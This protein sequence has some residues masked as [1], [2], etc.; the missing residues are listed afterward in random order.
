[1][2][3]RRRVRLSGV[4]IL[5][6]SALVLSG[7]AAGPEPDAAQA[8]LTAFQ[9]RVLDDYIVFE[10]AQE[11][12]EENG[13]TWREYYAHLFDVRHNPRALAVDWL[14]EHEARHRGT[15][16]GLDALHAALGYLCY[17]DYSQGL[18]REKSPAYYELL[19]DHYTRFESLGEVCYYG[20]LFEDP[21]DFLL[22]MELFTAKSSHRSVQARAIAAKMLLHRRAGEHEEQRGCAEILMESYPDIL[23]QN[24]PCGELAQQGLL[25]PHS[26]ELLQVGATAPEIRGYDLD[27]NPVSL[28]DFRGQVVVMSF[29]GFW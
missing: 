26:E 9:Q 27:G 20:N 22:T 1:M 13:Y 3:H 15:Q 23:Y 12:S 16:V 29:F 10:K 17:L 18:A 8:E 21:G 7:C 24:T 19:V 25:P 2:D 28:S 6:V 11:P 5:A 4:A 14:E